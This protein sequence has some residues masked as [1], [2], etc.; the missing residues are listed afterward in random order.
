MKIH[1]IT[2]VIPFKNTSR[3]RFDNFKY[4]VDKILQT[5][6]KLIVSEQRTT[7]KKVHSFLKSHHK[8]HQIE[9]VIVKAGTVFNKCKLMNTAV[10]HVNTPYVWFNDSDC[11]LKFQDI[12]SRDI[13][14]VDVI[15]PFLC[16]KDTNYSQRRQLLSNKPIKISFTGD[17]AMDVRYI[18][19]LGA[20]SFIINKQAF[21][22]L[23]GMDESFTGWGFEDHDLYYRIYTSNLNFTV[24]HDSMGIH[25]HHDTPVVNDDNES[26]ILEKH[27]KSFRE[28]TYIQSQVLSVKYPKK[29]SNYI[30]RQIQIDSLDPVNTSKSLTFEKSLKSKEP[31]KKLIHA[32]NLYTNI[33]QDDTFETFENSINLAIEH[34]KHVDINLISAQETM[35]PISQKL[36]FESFIP[37]RNTHTEFKDSRA[38]MYLK[39]MLDQAS[40]SCGEDD[41]ICYSNTD[42]IFDKNIYNYIHDCNEDVIEF[43]RRDVDTA[44][45]LNNYTQKTTGIDM[46][47]IKNY[48]YKQY[49]HLIPDMI[50][51]E[52]HWDTVL[53]GIFNKHH[54]TTQCVDKIYHVS[55]DMNWDL[56]KLSSAGELNKQKY[57][58]SIKYGIIDNQSIELHPENLTIIIDQTKDHDC[59]DHIY[60]YSAEHQNNNNIILVE[61]MVEQS[62]YNI[63]KLFNINHLPVIHTNENTQDIDQLIPLINLAVNM[64][65][66]NYKH[67]NIKQLTNTGLITT[68]DICV[69][70]FNK[71]RYLPLDQLIEE[72]LRIFLN[73]SGL[74]EKC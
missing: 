23:G 10:T 63:G 22:N 13:P 53:S 68:H 24:L 74:L 16:V 62:K 40:S 33:T 72:D 31:C 44:R 70:E 58:E 52:P 38:L 46:F 71:T 60:Q 34:T 73:D 9:H 37:S 54:Y 41:V 59:A 50:I 30:K 32:C 66:H 12:L 25:L 7:S 4:V 6:V 55:H 28:I 11:V 42:L 5:P 3:Q 29:S 49:R 47:A 56:R 1:D 8:S 14:D 18:Q 65:S 69:D 39:D 51:G 20:Q 43:F 64:F 21:L 45:D 2:F 35:D 48:V 17:D 67:V 27:G 36:V 26:Y 15:Q 61:L 19:M 57:K